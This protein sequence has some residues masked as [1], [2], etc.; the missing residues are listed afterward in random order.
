MKS[1][2]VFLGLAL[3][4]GP[5]ATGT[6]TAQSDLPGAGVLSYLAA[7]TTLPA[8][9]PAAIPKPLLVLQPGV[10]VRATYALCG[11]TRIPPTIV[12]GKFVELEREAF[13]VEVTDGDRR[14]L[15]QVAIDDLLRLEVGTERPLTTRGTMIGTLT[16]VALGVVGASIGG[17]NGDAEYG[18]GA[19]LG[20]LVGAGVGALIG[21]RSTAT[22]WKELPLYGEAYCE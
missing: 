12:T 14:Q 17:S 1:I 9:F 10:P 21:S 18:S 3:S 6:S 4:L 15:H 5:L 2:L 7:D 22:D 11:D 8:V 19:A 13:E 16:G 20:G